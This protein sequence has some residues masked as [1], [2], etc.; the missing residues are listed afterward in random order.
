MSL[1]VASV[2][3]IALTAATALNVIEIATASTARAKLVEWWV[4]FDGVTSTNT[5]V[6]VELARATAAIT[7]TTFTPL[8]FDDFA[9]TALTTCKHTATV[10][11]TIGD[12]LEIHRI[13]PTS[14]VL[15]QYPLGREI[16][17]PVSS[18]LRLRLTAAQTVN[19]TVGFI[20]EE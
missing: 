12:V 15:I 18:F 8:K 7:G 16:Q 4:E 3:A 19:A 10:A 5:P 20:W 2:D 9:P 17:I 1:Y 11:G 14:G 6:K 13:P